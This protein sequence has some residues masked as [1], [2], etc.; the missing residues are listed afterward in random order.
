MT[1]WFDTLMVYSLERNGKTAL[2]AIMNNITDSPHRPF[3]TNN[4]PTKT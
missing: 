3:Q 1:S 2:L 4:I